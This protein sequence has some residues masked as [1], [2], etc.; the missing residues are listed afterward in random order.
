MLS[1]LSIQ[2]RVIYALFMREIITRFGRNNL[3]FLWFALEPMMFVVI[4][5]VARTLLHQ[6][7]HS[8]ALVPFLVIG[9]SN[10]LVWRFCTARGM[11]AIEGNRG[12]LNYRNIKIQDIFLARMLL[13]AAGVTT[14]FLFLWLIFGIMGLMTWPNDP[15]LLIVG[16]FFICWFCAAFGTFLGCLT[17]LSDLAKRIWS[18]IGYIAFFFSGVY[19]EV[20]WLPPA[21]QKLILMV[22]LVHPVE[23][24]RAGY[25][26]DGHRAHYSM[27]YITVSCL[28]MTLLSG[29]IMRNRALRNPHL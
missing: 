4:I 24:A 3:G 20:D 26:G 16:W 28:I 14:S 21:L 22:P 17:E 6:T 18:P 29:L 10:L 11:G 2:G 9:Y 12:L 23:M 15:L 5:I 19:F 8:V 25:W 1:A 13:E 27:A 7:F